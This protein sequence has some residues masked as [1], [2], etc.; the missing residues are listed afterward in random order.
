MYER[1]YLKEFLNTLSKMENEIEN[2]HV[3]FYSAGDKKFVNKVLKK[4]SGG[5]RS[6]FFLIYNRD[7]GIL[8]IH[9]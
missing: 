5:K 8:K 3:V 9:A 1:S 4:L 7:F 6:T 2:F